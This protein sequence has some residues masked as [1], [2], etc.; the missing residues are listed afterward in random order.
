MT[1]A[2][3]GG[4]NALFTAA[5][6]DRFACAI[7]VAYPCTFSL[8]MQAERDLNWEDGTDVC[9]QV[10]QV[11]SY[12]EMSDLAS[13]FIPRPYMILAGSATRYS[14]L[15]APARS[16]PRSPRNYVLAGVPERFRYVEHD[17]EHGYQ[18]SLRQE[19]YGWLLRWLKGEGD[20]S[21]YA[22]PG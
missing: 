5:I 6:E 1:G 18:Q 21:P 10:P 7:P 9:N 17:E 3:G 13:L 15:P 19:A 16:P 2:S 20:G 14:P 4:L 11:M 22:R 12:A 8:A